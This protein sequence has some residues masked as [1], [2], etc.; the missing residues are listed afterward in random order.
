MLDFFVPIWYNE[1]ETNIQYAGQ[2]INKIPAYCYYPNKSIRRKQHV[3]RKNFPLFIPMVNN[4]INNYRRIKK[5]YSLDYRL[6]Q[7]DL[8]VRLFYPAPGK[9]C[10]Q[11]P[12]ELQVFDNK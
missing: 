2:T 12:L 8:Q 3:N 10:L 1:N 7:I 6:I 5:I 9:E 11:Q 4:W